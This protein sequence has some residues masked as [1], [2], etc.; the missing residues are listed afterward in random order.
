MKAHLTLIL[1]A[2]GAILIAVGVSVMMDNYNDGQ[3]A[4]AI[5]EETKP[6]VANTDTTIQEGLVE[7]TARKA[8]ELGVANARQEFKQQ[9]AEDKRN[10]PETAARADRAVPRSVL[11]NFA[12]R[13]AARE[14]LACPQ[15]QC[16]EGDTA[17][18]APQR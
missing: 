8:Y 18:D 7:E 2:I 16:A 12:K 1:Y 17:K 13:R 3:R 15:G 10:E 11:N 14:R 9:Q 6:I 5:V 4:E